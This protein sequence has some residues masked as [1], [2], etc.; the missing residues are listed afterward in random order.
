MEKVSSGEGL[1]KEEAVPQTYSQ[2]LAIT[3]GL[4]SPCAHGACSQVP[5]RQ[6][7]VCSGEDA[8]QVPLLECPLHPRQEHPAKAVG[9]GAI[10]N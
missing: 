10:Y 2:A 7:W 1:I 9:A 5:S 8:T 4:L 3:Q 6:L